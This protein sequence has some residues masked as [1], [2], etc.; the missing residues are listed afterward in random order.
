VTCFDR[1]LKENPM[2]FMALV[3]KGFTQRMLGNKGDALQCFEKA[4]QHQEFS[5]SSVFTDISLQLGWLYCDAGRFDRALDILENYEKQPGSRQDYSL[6]R[7]LG[8][9]YAGNGQTDRAIPALQKAVRENPHDAQSLSLLGELYARNE[10]GDDI[11]LTLC[12]QA[13]DIDDTSWQHWFR[14]ALVKK[15]MGLLQEA[16]DVIVESLRRNRRE[17]DALYLAGQIYRELGE[18]RK[19]RGMLQ[20][21]LNIAP[22]HRGALNATYNRKKKI[23]GNV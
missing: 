10:Q 22:K 3:N 21:V 9:A 12:R 2:N 17:V 8:K 7:L 5:G 14:L 4:S 6:Y 1:V 11:A 20:R 16:R 13:V 18:E 19:A 15:K 23:R